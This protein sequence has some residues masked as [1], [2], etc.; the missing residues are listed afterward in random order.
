MLQETKIK[1]V[2]FPTCKKYFW[3]LEA[4][5]ICSKIWKHCMNLVGITCS[6]VHVHF[7]CVC[8]LFH[9][10]HKNVPIL[11]KISLTL[12]CQTIPSSDIKLN[13]KFPTIILKSISHCS[14]KCWAILPYKHYHVKMVHFLWHYNYQWTNSAQ[15]SKNTVLM[16]ILDHTQST[17]F[18]IGKFL[19]KL[20]DD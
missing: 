13:E 17:F 6:S 19:K 9:Y 14:G 2:L 15:Q 12:T 7:C 4:V 10:M 3:W 18:S 20:A 5:L 11:Q 8:S 16:C 1:Q